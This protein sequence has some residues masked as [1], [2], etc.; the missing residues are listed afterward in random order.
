MSARHADGSSR[1]RTSVW[2]G[3][4]VAA[5]L[6]LRSLAL[7]SA[8]HRSPEP[9][10][11]P[12]GYVRQA[13][14]F[15]AH[16]HG[17]HW[18]F[19]AFMYGPLV[20]APLYPFVLSLFALFPAGFPL[21]AALMQIAIGTASVAGVYVIGRDMH[22]SRAGL[23]AGAIYAS[24]LPTLSLV[25]FFLQ[26]QLHVPLVIIGL[27]LFVHAAA[28]SAPLTRF[29]LAGG[30][31]GL[32]ALVRSMPLYY[33]GPA[34]LLYVVLGQDRRR[35][36]RQAIALL[37]GFLVV[38]LPWCVY[39]SAK[40]G[41]LILIDNMGSAA[42]G[43]TY[44]E[45]RPEIHTAPPAT[46][47]ESL[48]M[49]WRA[50]TRYPARFWGDRLADFQRL[51]R[52]TGGQWLELGPPVASRTEA[53]ALKGIAH[54]SDLL[55]ALSGVLAPLGVALARRR[56]EVI[57][58]AL[59]VV[60][61]LGLLV[62]FAWN[63]VRYRSPYEPELIGLAAIVL[64][65]GW[66]RPRRVAFGLALAASLAIGAALVASL[67]ETAR[68][69]ATYGFKEWVPA[70]DAHRASIVGDAGFRMLTGGRSVDLRLSPVRSTPPE[71]PVR[72]RVFL[73]GREVDQV[74]LDAGERQLRYVWTPPV[75]Y[76]ELRATFENS[77][78]PAPLLV[79]V[80]TP[81]H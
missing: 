38:V 44:R 40:T 17:W 33:I 2:L 11:D 6:L 9:W 69:R 59:W 48:R 70:G 41:Q 20:K 10:V 35:V 46:V 66:A 62:A 65:G 52:L 71:A 26:E 15:V 45:V 58:V 49:V 12:D 4:I 47:V 19:N 43:V 23:I 75:A 80:V 5:A 24:W 21:S 42:L 63:G 73:G 3:V 60:L 31:L 32:A 27:A 78:R 14:L 76:V 72:V 68:A 8:M 77:Q 36:V 28:R 16:G 55:F 79:D 61:H 56:R 29:A 37:L 7:L 54:T 34:A 30:V 22:S 74:T 57:L 39:V 64:A 1:L 18:D 51:F 81:R 13:V 53:L 25:P 50:A 67:P